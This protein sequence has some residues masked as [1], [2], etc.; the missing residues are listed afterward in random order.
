MI[1]Y[2][3]SAVVVMKCV[4]KNLN[5]LHLSY[6]VEVDTVARTCPFLEKVLHCAETLMWSCA[7]CDA[8]GPIKTSAIKSIS[9]SIKSKM[10]IPLESHHMI[11]I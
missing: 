10:K 11:I 9:N 7:S 4:I 5:M 2:A 1:V 6:N 3:S 8:L